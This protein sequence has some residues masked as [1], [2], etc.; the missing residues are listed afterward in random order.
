MYLLVAWRPVMN[1]I[2]NLCTKNVQVSMKM[3]AADLGEISLASLAATSQEGAQ[4]PEK[5]AGKAHPRQSLRHFN[6]YAS[7]LPANPT[8]VTCRRRPTERTAS[9]L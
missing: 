2:L 8:L 7:I 3:E 1:M 6:G 9:K 4:A 5:A